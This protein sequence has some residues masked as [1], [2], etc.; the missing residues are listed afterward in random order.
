LSAL[1]FELCTCHEARR[2]VERG[3]GRPARV[4]QTIGGTEQRC[5]EGHALQQSRRVGGRG[6]QQRPEA[7]RVGTTH[8]QRKTEGVRGM[9][10]LTVA[11]MAVSLLAMAAPAMAQQID[12]LGLITSGAVLPFVG[13]AAPLTTG[14]PNLIAPGSMSFL[15]VASPIGANP[16]LHLFFFDSACT[17]GP[18]SVGRPLTT[19][20]VALI[21]VDSVDQV[22]PADGL[23]AAG[24]AGGDGFHL[25][26]LTLP[27]HARVLWVNA[28]ANFVRTLEPIGIG[29][30][31]FAGQV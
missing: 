24:Q 5:S 9:R 1:V 14:G 15:E 11:L 8:M 31:D 7:A 18:E 16:N 21:R 27:I 28:A 30:W 17:R 22:T 12:P 19:N 2:V 20:D 29:S 23:T 25:D 10:K 6:P 3:G 26:P 13:G 4:R